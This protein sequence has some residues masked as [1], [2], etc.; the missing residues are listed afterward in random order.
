MQGAFYGVGASVITTIGISANKLL[1]T[2][3]GKDRLLFAICLV[4]G[5]VT[6][7]TETE[8]V[9]LFVA[10]GL[11]SLVAKM[12]PSRGQG[13]T[14][15]A[16]SPAWAWLLTGL[17]VV[18]S[19]ALV[20]KIGLYFA[21]AGAF[22]FGSGLAII[23]FLHGGVVNEFH[24]LSERQFLDA[25]AVAMITPGPVVITVAF[26]GYLVSGALGATAAAAGVFLPC[27]HP[28]RTQS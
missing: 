20:W 17:H 27:S 7:W 2:T 23:P 25:V 10:C 28:S 6:V 18:G 16:V 8:V 1:R 21:A 4:S 14:M 12:P 5:I 22:V 19:S 24:W 9:W 11:V 3:L 13:A 26:I 15:N